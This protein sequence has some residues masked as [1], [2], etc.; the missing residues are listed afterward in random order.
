MPR[1]SLPLAGQDEEREVP[2]YVGRDLEA[3]L[4]EVARRGL[5]EQLAPVST[6]SKMPCPSWGISALRCRIGTLLN[7]TEGS[8]CHEKNCYA[9]KG[10][11]KFSNDQARLEQAYQGLFDVR[12]T[13]ALIHQ[14]R[15]YADRYFRLF[16]SGDLQGQNHL[17]NLVSVAQ[18]VPDVSFWCPT[19][20]SKTVKAVLKEIGEFPENLIVRVSATMID[21]PPPKGFPLTSTVVS[22]PDEANYPAPSQGGQ[23]GACRSCWGPDVQNVAYRKH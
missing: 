7:D 5:A 2:L 4:R 3:D 9:K 19:R 13:P 11:F 12:W 14:V 16:H 6:T 23:C 21:G 8:V 10:R 22:D 17:K 1:L 20:E 18:A 15:W